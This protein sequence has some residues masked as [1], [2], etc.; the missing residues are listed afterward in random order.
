MSSS[1]QQRS[2]QPERPLRENPQP[3]IEAVAENY[4]HYADAWD[5]SRSATQ[6]KLEYETQ[7]LYFGHNSM[8]RIVCLGLNN[9]TRQLISEAVYAGEGTASMHQLVFLIKLLELLR[10]QNSILDPDVYFQDPVFTIRETEFLTSLGYSVVSDPQAFNVVDGE[11]LVFAPRF[12]HDLIP[13]FLAVALPAAYIGPD[14]QDAY[15]FVDETFTNRARATAI[16]GELRRF[17]HAR[18][19]QHMLIYDAQ[20]WCQATRVYWLRTDEETGL[21]QSPVTT[22]S[23]TQASL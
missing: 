16:M 18:N 9:F 13:R 4:R 21:T 14:L 5:N 23:Q 8:K 7:F 20:Q 6:L 3:S 1:T 17:D 12:P 11:T 15:E 22:Q 2:Q 19:K 10:G